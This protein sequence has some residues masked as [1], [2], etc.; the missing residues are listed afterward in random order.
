[1][2]AVC[3]FFKLT[4]K[5]ASYYKLLYKKCYQQ[6]H[7]HRNDLYVFLLCLLS[8]RFLSCAYTCVGQV[9]QK[10]LRGYLLLITS[11]KSNTF[12]LL[13]TFYQK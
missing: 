1:M 3:S 12:T 2:T 4:K 9:I 10:W 13:I 7:P 5:V 8:R 11:Y 6:S